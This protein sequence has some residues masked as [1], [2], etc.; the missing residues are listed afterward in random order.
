MSAWH[1]PLAD[2]HVRTLA[3]PSNAASRGSPPWLRWITLHAT[4]DEDAAFFASHD[5]RVA[6]T[7]ANAMTRSPNRCGRRGYLDGLRGSFR[8]AGYGAGRRR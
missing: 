5:A 3:R 6:M 4:E 2:C 8:S 1:E 7:A